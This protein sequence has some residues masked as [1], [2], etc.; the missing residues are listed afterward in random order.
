MIQLF[1]IGLQGNGSSSHYDN[2]IEIEI[3]DIP[4]V[5]S[6]VRSACIGGDSI[7]PVVNSASF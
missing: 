4:K 5:Q 2:Y 7:Q 6:Q 3:R 1:F